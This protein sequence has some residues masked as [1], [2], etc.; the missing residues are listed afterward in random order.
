MQTKNKRLDKPVLIW[1]PQDDFSALNNCPKLLAFLHEAVELCNPSKVTI[2]TDTQQDIEY[3]REKVIAEKDEYLLEKWGHTYHHDHPGDQ[4]PIKTQYLSEA[5]EDCC[6]DEDYISRSSGLL[7]IGNDFNGAMTGKE[8]FVCLY[9]VGPADS[10]FSIPAVQLTDSSYA[11]HN[12]MILYRQGYKI[13]RQM[14]DGNDDFISILHSGGE[15]ASGA[16]NHADKQFAYV[17]PLNQ[18]VY[19]YGSQYAE[20]S[21]GLYRHAYGLIIQK[22]MKEKWLAENMMIMGLSGPLGG[23]RVYFAGA[24]PQECEKASIALSPNTTIAGNGQALLKSINGKTTAVSAGQGLFGVIPD[25][26]IHEEQLLFDAITTPREVIVSNILQDEKESLWFWVRINDKT[27]PSGINYYAKWHEGIFDRPGSEARRTPRNAGYCM[28][29]CE[30]ANADPKLNAPE[31]IKIDA[32]LYGSNDKASV[33]IAEAFDWNHGVTYNPFVNCNQ[34]GISPAEYINNHITFGKNLNIAPRIFA[35]NFPSQFEKN[36][37]I[38]GRQFNAVW[39][40]WARGRILGRLDA[41]ETALGFIPKYEDI[42]MLFDYMF[43]YHYGKEIY[44]VQFTITERQDW[45]TYG[46]AN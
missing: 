13:F 24:F 15:T 19:I 29:I 17:D 11:A 12:G 8:M 18:K 25:V 39:L 35:V 9:S 46:K 36:D 30:L 6:P 41:N 14:P 28:K 37:G 32:I 45:D 2:L 10:A 43:G 4:R 44:D 31:G 23:E 42:Q 20:N 16:V 34:A 27:P 3:I 5:Q 21:A 22:A 26:N 7:R 38:S 1:A 40:Q 33:P